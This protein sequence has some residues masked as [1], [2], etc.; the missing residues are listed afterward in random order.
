MRVPR[1]RNLTAG[2]RAAAAVCAACRPGGR[3]RAPPGGAGRGRPAAAPALATAPQDAARRPGSPG[4]G[5]AAAARRRRASA[6][7]RAHA[8]CIS[9]GAAA[10]GITRVACLSLRTR[11]S[12]CACLLQAPA[13]ALWTSRR[14][15]RRWASR[16]RRCSSSSSCLK[17]RLAI[18]TTASTTA[19]CQAPSG[20]AADTAGW[21]LQELPRVSSDVL[22]RKRGGGG[23]HCQICTHASATVSALSLEHAH[24]F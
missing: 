10:A 7:M 19:R 14:C 21:R 2:L 11:A 9:P 22:A 16:P 12:L 15:R 5:G 24:A 20:P 18:A 23:T 6:V 4:G 3:A 17:A 8:C 1:V 13:T